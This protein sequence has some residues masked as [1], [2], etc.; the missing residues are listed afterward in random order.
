MEF[1]AVWFEQDCPKKWYGKNGCQNVL[2]SLR[3]FML[4]K[5]V[6]PFQGYFLK[7]RK[8]AKSCIRPNLDSDSLPCLP[9]MRRQKIDWTSAIIFS[10]K[11]LKKS[12]HWCQKKA[13][14]WLQTVDFLPT[15]VKIEGRQG[16]KSTV[17]TRAKLLWASQVVFVICLCWML[18]VF[19]ANILC[20]PTA[21]GP[22]WK[23]TILYQI[24]DNT[25][26]F[27]PVWTSINTV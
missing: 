5:H 20:Q 8:S 10:W 1:A 13:S 16:R 23:Q 2:Q 3:I 15:F 19:T 21:D 17:Q 22:Q 27:Y 4:K 9:L 24:C 25:V 11:R 12:F 7:I 18:P 14:H 26:C 6:V